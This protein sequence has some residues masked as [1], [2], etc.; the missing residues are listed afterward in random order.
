MYCAGGSERRPLRTEA[1]QPEAV[2]VL[3][4]PVSAPPGS[5]D[6]SVAAAREH[7]GRA[8]W[9][10]ARCGC[11]AE[12]PAP[13]IN[14]SRSLKAS[15]L[16]PFPT[17]SSD[18]LEDG[19]WWRRMLFKDLDRLFAYFKQKP[20]PPAHGGALAFAWTD[21]H[22]NCHAQTYW[23]LPETRGNFATHARWLLQHFRLATYLLAHPCVARQYSAGAGAAKG[24]APAPPQQAHVPW[25]GPVVQQS[26]QQQCEPLFSRISRTG[27]Q[28]ELSSRREHRVHA[29]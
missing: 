7:Q 24:S 15:L 26:A 9:N 23:R 14:V 4:G 5:P 10:H 12:S 11:F 8:H 2:R 25:G 20:A 3:R 18:L 6:A 19:F 17:S 28:R 27:N 13:C 22:T 1:R 21:A 29:D 16:T